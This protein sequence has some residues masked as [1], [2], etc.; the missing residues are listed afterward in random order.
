MTTPPERPHDGAWT[1]FGRWRRRS[2]A[3]RLLGVA[4]LLLALLL[5][6]MWARAPRDDG[7]HARPP[8]VATV[9][10]PAQVRAQGA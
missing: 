9:A 4:L 7:A 1:V 10:P 2:P 6:L 8:A 3:T 5:T